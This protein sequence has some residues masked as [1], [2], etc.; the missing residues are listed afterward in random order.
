MFV[1]RALKLVVGLVL[2]WL[3]MDS[4]NLDESQELTSND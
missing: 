4:L 2:A 1:A 3:G